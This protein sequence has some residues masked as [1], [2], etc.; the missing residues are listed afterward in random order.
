MVGLKKNNGSCRQLGEGKI[1]QTLNKGRIC[2]TKSIARQKK[3]EVG[4]IA[5][6]TKRKN[7]E[8]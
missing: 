7:I 8:S 4:E 5:Q 2:P 3:K 6:K 1:K